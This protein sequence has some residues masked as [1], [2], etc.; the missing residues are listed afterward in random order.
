MLLRPGRGLH[1]PSSVRCPPGLRVW[2]PVLW[3]LVGSELC[4]H[5]CTQM[6]LLGWDPG[7]LLDALRV[8]L[9]GTV[10]PEEAV[11]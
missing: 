9:D 1:P 11:P 10:A 8:L 4:P 5:L 2:P 7:L 6:A 3:G